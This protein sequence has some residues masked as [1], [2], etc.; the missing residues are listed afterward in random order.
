[1][2]VA[3]WTSSEAQAATC[4]EV[5][6]E[7]NASGVSIDSRT[8]KSGDLFVAIEGPNFDGHKFVNDALSKGAAAAVVSRVPDGAEPQAALLIVDDTL[9]ALEGLAAASRARTAAKIIAV[10]GSVGKTGTKEAL[11]EVLSAQG[12]TYAT[13]GSLNNHWGL[14]L[15]LAR[16]P[17]T[18]KFGVL[19]LGMNHPGEIEP[20][21]KLARPHVALIT[22]IETVHSAHFD[23]IEDIADAKAEIFSGLEPGGVAILNMD[24]SQYV[25]LSS[26]AKAA[27]V[28]NIISFGV[29]VSADFRALSFETDADFS[30]V[31]AQFAGETIDYRISIPGQ[32][33]V[34]NSLGVL[35]GVAAAGGNI[36]AAA[37][38]LSQLTPPKGRGQ[39]C[40]VRLSD[41]E[42]TLIDDSYNASP[43]SVAA[44]LSVLGR[45][46]LGKNGRRIAVLG[47]MLELGVNSVRRHQELAQPIN[48]NKIDL[49]FTAGNDMAVLSEVL[50]G[51]M[52]GGHADNSEL[53]APVVQTAVRAGDAVSVKG[54]AGSK[55]NVVVQALL[56]LDANAPLVVN[57]G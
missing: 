37:T 6:S 16:L 27:G 43:V 55:M 15:S 41:G 2:I 39:S 8:V 21:V 30:R 25:R 9:K 28:K 47:D 18:A 5:T 50:P 13:E 42:F 36:V 51:E 1:M 23:S 33:W 4:G 29:D 44:S 17:R 34:M 40:K 20:L 32:H 49:V 45:I 7:W 35:G 10:T 3:L 56:A 26:Q 14:P 53:L 52:Q 48:E 38:V 11:K 46:G 24:N 19:E 54:S 57:G 31:T 22:T 12:E